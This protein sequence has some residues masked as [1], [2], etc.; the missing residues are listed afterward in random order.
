MGMRIAYLIPRLPGTR[1]PRHREGGIGPE[2][3]ALYLAAI[4]RYDRLRY[5]LP[6]V[7]AGDVAFEF[8]IGKQS[9]IGGDPRA[10]ELEFHAAVE[11]KPERTIDRFTR[12]FF[13]MAPYDSNEAIDYYI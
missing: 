1:R 10:M 6:A 5:V 2:I 7:G 4:A 8:A 9:G 11:T 13:K 12:W 3:E